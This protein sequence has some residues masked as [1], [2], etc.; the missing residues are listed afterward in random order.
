M[1]RAVLEA[2]GSVMTNKYAE[3]YPRPAL[4]RRLP[5]RRHRR[6]AGHRARLAP[7]RLPLRQRA[8]EF[9]QPGQPGRVHGADEARRHLHGPRSRCRRAPHPRLARST[10]RASGSTSCP[11]ACARTTSASTW[12]RS[13]AL[14]REHKPKIIIAG[15]SAYAR[16][17][18]FARF[19]EIADAVGAYLHGR[20]GAF[21]RAGR[22]RRAS[23]AVPAR[24]CRHD[25]DAQDAARS[26]RRHDPHQR[27]GASPRRST[28]RS[29]P[30]SRAGR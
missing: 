24:P 9:R 17:W 21:R 1:S 29:S 28:R 16:H 27:R 8:A 23:L 25:D 14:A 12:T 10:C 26:A 4:L 22:G 15:G 13:S 5:V 2:Q 3:G 11:T 7:V 30:A 20:H 18:D 6:E 19:R